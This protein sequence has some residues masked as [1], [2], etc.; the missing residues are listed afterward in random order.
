MSLHDEIVSWKVTVF[1]LVG[2]IFFFLFTLA[3]LS[4]TKRKCIVI[5]YNKTPRSPGS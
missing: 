1:S 2:G 3:T 5:S 4:S